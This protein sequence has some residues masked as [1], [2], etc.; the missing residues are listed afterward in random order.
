MAHKEPGMFSNNRQ[1][2]T[3]VEMMFASALILVTIG[4]TIGLFVMCQ[5]QWHAN[6][7]GMTTSR[8]TSMA[9][10]RLV[11]GVATNS[12]VT[13][14]GL[15]SASSVSIVYSN[16]AYSGSNYPPQPWATNHYLTSGTNDGSWRLVCANPFA[17]TKW[18]DYNKRASNIV[19]WMDTNSLASRQLIC[20]YVSTSSVSTNVSGLNIQLTVVRQDGRYTSTNRVGTFILMRNRPL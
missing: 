9:L 7:L 10:S 6:L 20:N 17:G 12:G 2:F 3:I 15:R 11:Y 1:G 16:S 4:A 18:I 19:Y 5:K 13:N 8:G 14:S